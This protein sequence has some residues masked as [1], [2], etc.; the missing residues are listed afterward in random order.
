MNP[1]SKKPWKSRPSAEKPSINFNPLLESLKKL[2]PLPKKPSKSRPF[3]ENACEKKRGSVRFRLSLQLPP[4]VLSSV[5][6]ISR[7]QRESYQAR[8]HR[9]PVQLASVA[10]LPD[11]TRKKIWISACRTPRAKDGVWRKWFASVAEE[12]A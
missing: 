6:H 11:P 8:V 10:G 5:A 7:D 9:E 2:N 12:H 3:A 1:L 4:Y